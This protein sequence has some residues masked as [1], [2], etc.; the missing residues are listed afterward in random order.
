MTYFI[1]KYTDFSKLISGLY[2]NA[3]MCKSF[4]LISEEAMT[5][6]D[7]ISKPQFIASEQ[8]FGRAYQATPFLS[9]QRVSLIRFILSLFKCTLLKSEPRSLYDV[10]SRANK[11]SLIAIRTLS[12]NKEGDPEKQQTG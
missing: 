3:E 6:F 4:R 12:A 1:V 8:S 11:C 9:K 7:H 2:V 10:V 5:S